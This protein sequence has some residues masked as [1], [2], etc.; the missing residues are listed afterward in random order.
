MTRSPTA[1]RPA[2][3]A[4]AAFL[5]A[6]AASG[7]GASA[8]DLARLLDDLSPDA[9][10]AEAAHRLVVRGELT[11]FQADRLLAGKTGGLTL[12][13]YLIL[14]PLAKT[15]D[16]LAFKA[17]HRLMDRLVSVWLP[18]PGGDPGRWDA[19]LEAARL[20]A[21]LA[22]PHILGVL[23]VNREADRPYVVTEYVDGAG[24]DAVA[25]LAGRLPASRACDLVRQVALALAHAHGMG[26][27]HGR[28]SAAAVRV[29]RPGGGGPERMAVKL[30]GFAGDR[31]A[32]AT[33]ADD[34]HALGALLAD[35]LAGRE[36]GPV[37]DDTPP[38]VADLIVALGD[39]DPARR[40]AAAVVA[41]RLA[42]LCE[43]DFDLETVGFDLPAAGPPP[44]SLADGYLSGLY[45]TPPPPGGCPFADLMAAQPAGP[46]SLARVATAAGDR[47]RLLLT[48]A[49]LAAAVTAATVAVVAAML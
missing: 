27:A 40:P 20:A 43:T 45:A 32:A 46:A 10:A 35:L 25:R 13:P 49:G 4:R 39:R 28:L 48:V 41:E 16:G 30:D 44:G 9:S 12:G 14:E 17:R 15:G 31:P 42:L 29:G 47:R 19:R 36:A 38:A 8:R 22:H 6:V 24:L 11:R 37:P 23:D 26:V 7:V 1:P 18:A 3:S 2:A 33:P 5:K 34:L 21:R